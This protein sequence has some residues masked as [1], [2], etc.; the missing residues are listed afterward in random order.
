MTINV[1]EALDQDTC[2]KLR[3]ERRSAGSYSN[4]VYVEGSISYFY[5]LIS[6]QSPSAKLLEML[7][8]GERDKDLM[9][10]ISKASLRTVD[11]NLGIPPDVVLFDDKRYRIV[12]LANWSTFG[13]CIAIGAAE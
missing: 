8:E 12:Q 4:G 6:P 2:L 3:V 1:S 10:F 13:H 9:M 5:S 7:P 11:D